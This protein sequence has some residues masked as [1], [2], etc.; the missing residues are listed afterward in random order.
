VRAGGE[1]TAGQGPVRSGDAQQG[2]CVQALQLVRSVDVRVEL[3]TWLN[4]EAASS[5]ERVCV[6]SLTYSEEKVASTIVPRGLGFVHH[7]R[8]IFCRAVPNPNITIRNFCNAV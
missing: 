3:A 6:R 2:C 4:P 1:V 8:T 5:E 7:S